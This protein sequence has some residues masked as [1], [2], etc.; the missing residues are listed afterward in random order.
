MTKIQSRLLDNLSFNEVRKICAL[1]NKK[2]SRIH[3]SKGLKLKLLKLLHL[4][5]SCNSNDS[6]IVYSFIGKFLIKSKNYCSPSYLYKDY[7]L[8]N[9]EKRGEGGSGVYYKI[10]KN[11]GLKVL[12]DTNKYCHTIN[13]LKRSRYWKKCKTEFLAQKIMSKSGVALKVFNLTYVY[14]FQYN[15]FFPAIEMEHFEHSGKDNLKL[16]NFILKKTVTLG[17]SKISIFSF[18]DLISHIEKALRKEGLIHGDLHRGNILIKNSNVK[19]IDFGI[20]HQI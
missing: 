6:N 17:E 19:L 9:L 3:L 16:D 18:S 2:K 13:E 20:V 10:S 4:K 7:V 12:L 1:Y 14:S 5:R 8:G 15:C 11:R